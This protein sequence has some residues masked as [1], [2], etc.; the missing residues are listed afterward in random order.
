MS[1][2][3]ITPV[4]SAGAQLIRR[5]GNGSF[6]IA[7][8]EHTGPIIVLPGH[9]VAW[10]APAPG[11]LSIEHLQAVVDAAADIDILV[12]GCGADFLAPPRVLRDALKEHGI[13]LEWMDTGAACRTFNVLL[14][15]SRRAAAALMVID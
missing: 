13:V 3:D 4:P 10:A 14:T 9:A 1:A 15:E 5:Y 2:I 12:L 7:E 6:K 11:A 8:V